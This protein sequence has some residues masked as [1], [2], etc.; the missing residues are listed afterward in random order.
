VALQY[1]LDNALWHELSWIYAIRALSPRGESALDG[2]GNSL[3]DSGI[4]ELAGSADL[5]GDKLISATGVP[6][7][8][9][10]EKA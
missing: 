3:Q 4:Q 7:R 10:S 9:G 8:S 2:L 1:H 6:N 5:P